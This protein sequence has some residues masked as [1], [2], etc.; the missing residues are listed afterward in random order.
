MHNNNLIYV[1]VPY[2]VNI[3]EGCSDI[4]LPL[5]IDSAHVV[6]SN[7]VSYLYVGFGV[8]YLLIIE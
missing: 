8:S 2:K 3:A 7:K 5:R 4:L 1:Q 6:N